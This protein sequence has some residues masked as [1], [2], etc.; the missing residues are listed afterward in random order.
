[1]LGAPCPTT[2]GKD[3][4]SSSAAFLLTCSE[5]HSTV[6]FVRPYS[7]ARRRASSSSAV[8]GC[9]GCE[10]TA[11]ISQPV[12]TSLPAAENTPRSTLC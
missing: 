4:C 12:T 3:Q 1:M 9:G 10:E 7:F 8:S 5:P 11:D 6:D 2:S